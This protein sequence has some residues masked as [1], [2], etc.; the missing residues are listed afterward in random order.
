MAAL[1]DATAL[2]TGASS[3]IGEATAHVLAKRGADVALVAR[4]RDA[5]ESVARELEI[6]D[7]AEAIAF[8]ATRQGSSTQESDRYR[9]DKF[10]ESL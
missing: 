4:R 10:A 8:A 9:R 2:V 6:D 5:L 1:A 3:G 7:D